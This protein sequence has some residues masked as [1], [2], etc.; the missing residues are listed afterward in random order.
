M[1]IAEWGLIILVVLAPRLTMIWIGGQQISGD[2][3]LYMGVARNIAENFCVS[4]S[5]PSGGV[6]APHWGGN[7]LPG[8]PAFMAAVWWVSGGEFKFV[9]PAQSLVFAVAAAVLAAALRRAGAEANA[10]RL[11]VLVL[12]V[13]PSLVGWPRMLL[14]ETLSA[15]AAI[16]LL[17]E[18]VKSVAERRPRI[19]PTAIAMAIGIFIRYDFVLMLLPVGLTM[20]YILPVFQ[21]LRSLIAVLLICALPIVGWAARAAAVGLPPVPPYGLTPHGEELPP[22]IFK[23]IGVWLVYQHDLRESVWA[24]VNYDYNDFHPPLSAYRSESERRVVEG[25]IATLSKNFLGVSPPTEIDN[26]FAKLARAR[27]ETEPVRYWLVLPVRRALAMWLAPTPSMGW[28]VEV[29]D[30]KRREWRRA[31][32]H[33][34]WMEVADLIVENS[35]AVLAKGLVVLHRYIL[36]LSGLIMMFSLISCW[37][38]GQNN[39]TMSLAGLALVLALGRTFA[40]SQTLLVETRYL[41]PCLAWLDV[42]VTI[43]IHALWRHKRTI[44]IAA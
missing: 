15:A 3:F 10:V 11:V 9:P 34:D 27:I 43:Q 29:G 16:W 23:W 6:C 37:R 35:G 41:V 13:S 19:V 26:D 7:Q 38:R 4:L 39:L 40:F 18:L 42:A 21:A 28:P 22:G 30:Q 8:Y 31:L 25:H 2:S 36:L 17:A 33:Q 32:E 5:D 44:N 12:A 20:L 24:L 14:T 1:N